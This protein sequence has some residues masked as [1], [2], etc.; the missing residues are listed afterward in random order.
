MLKENMEAWQTK[1]RSKKKGKAWKE[2]EVKL[3]KV[4]GKKNVTRLNSSS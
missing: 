2:T 4:K 3:V 1:W